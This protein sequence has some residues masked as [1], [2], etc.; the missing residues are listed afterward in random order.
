MLGV[1]SDP[2]AIGRGEVRR[3]TEPATAAFGKDALSIQPEGAQTISTLNPTPSRPQMRDAIT[4]PINSILQPPSLTTSGPSSKTTVRKFIDAAA[5]RLL[6][7]P[8]PAHQPPLA[9]TAQ[10]PLRD[11]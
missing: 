5:L 9:R 8:K 1:G 7:Q 4:A 11:P 2:V 3:R 10:E 6:A